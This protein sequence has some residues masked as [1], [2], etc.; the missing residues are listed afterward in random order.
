MRNKDETILGKRS[1]DC[2]FFLKELPVVTDNQSVIPPDD[3][4]RYTLMF[5]NA[6]HR[7]E[8]GIL[9]FEYDHKQ[10]HHPWVVYF[11]PRT[12]TLLSYTCQF[13]HDLSCYLSWV[14]KEF[15][16]YI[17]QTEKL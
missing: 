17:E 10:D 8:G 15:E 2:S 3:K 5:G 14:Q 11:Q 13:I 6:Y 16:E 9:E 7:I 12:G 4:Y 1:G